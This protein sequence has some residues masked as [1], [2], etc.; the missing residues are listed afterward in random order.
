MPIYDYKCRACG[1]QFEELVKLGQ[2]P[3]CPSCDSNDLEKLLSLPAVSTEKTRKRNMAIGRRRAD[4]VRKE[5][6]HAEAEYTRNYIKEHS[7]E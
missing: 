7:G 2:T 4:S 3:N 6:K 1:T 5:Q